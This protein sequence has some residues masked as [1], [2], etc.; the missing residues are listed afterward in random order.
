MRESRVQVV[1]AASRRRLAIYAG[2]R[3]RY[4]ACEGKEGAGEVPITATLD[5]PC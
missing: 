3:E 2:M 4:D 5:S 1:A